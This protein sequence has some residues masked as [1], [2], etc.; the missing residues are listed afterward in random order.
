M[1]GVLKG[2]PYSNYIIYLALIPTIIYITLFWIMPIVHIF[3]ISLTYKDSFLLGSPVFVDGENYE[4]VFAMYRES[5][6]NSILL[7]FSAAVLDLV[8]GYPLAYLLVRKRILF[9]NVIRAS[10]VF[11]YFG[12]LYISYGLW[13]MFL[14]GGLFDIFYNLFGISYRQILYT[15]YAVIFGLSIFTLPLMVLYVSS[16]LQEVD[17]V[18]EE[19]ALTL[20][21]SPIKSFFKI[22]LPLTLPGAI[23]GFLACFGW[24]LGGYLIPLLLGGIES[25]NVITVKIVY[26][27]LQIHNY[28]V[29][30]ALA[31]ILTLMT[32]FTTYLTFKVT[33]FLK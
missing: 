7:P 21:A 22:T 27:T 31:V 13:N 19:A 3:I 15:P 6:K 26:L 33:K 18:L 17:P 2:N 23:A 28:G 32:M 24:N 11:P 9:K 10:L 12:D 20:G 4:T 8:L 16:N 25:G 29:A 5:I 14:P 1:P 30:A